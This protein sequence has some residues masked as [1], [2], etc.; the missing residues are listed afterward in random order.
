MV[1]EQNR[2]ASLPHARVSDCVH[3]GILSCASDALV[4]EAAGIMSE[5]RLHAVAITV[6]EGGW[7]VAVVSD[8]DVVAAGV[9]DTEPSV[10]Q[11]AATEPL[12]VSAG[13]SLQ[14][15]AQLMAEHGV[16]HLV[17]LDAVGGYRVGML[18]TLDLAAADAGVAG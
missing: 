5:H 6:H 14:C 3:V 15:A 17:V 11:A 4:A 12:A 10:L 13:E 8:L 18:S 9:S 16:A 2:V 1:N 7:P